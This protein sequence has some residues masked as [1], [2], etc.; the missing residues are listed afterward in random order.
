MKRVCVFCGSKDGDSPKWR[1]AAFATGV[2]LASRR[3]EVVTGGARHGLMGAVTDGALSVGGRVLGVIPHGLKR[4]EF[5]HPGLAE[6]FHTETMA[7]R[8]AKLV[9]LADG[10]LALPGGFGT[11]DEL[12]E[13]L[14]EAQIGLHLKPIGLL[15]Q[16]GY[17][18]PLRAWI[19]G[20]LQHGFIPGGLKDVLV[21]ADQPQ[22]LVDAL[23]RHTP[24]PPA[25]QWIKR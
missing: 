1:D 24:P 10:F 20:A 4:Q 7:E 2:A 25:V 12:F 19:S 8:K 18:A 22:A 23:L 9:A 16:D 5:E 3:L 11:M 17:Y 21:A 13:V 6:L 15:D 14:T